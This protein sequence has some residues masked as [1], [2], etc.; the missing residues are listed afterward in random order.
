MTGADIAGLIS[1]LASTGAAVPGAD[2]L[3]VGQGNSYSGAQQPAVSD[4]SGPLGLAPLTPL[5]GAGQ[6]NG[7]G[8]LVGSLLKL[9][10]AAM[11][12]L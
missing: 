3:G 1:A 7:V 6:S 8:D 10:P 9:A 4:M 2:Q 11:A 5:T 12:F